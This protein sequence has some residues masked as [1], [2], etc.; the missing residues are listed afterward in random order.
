MEELAAGMGEKCKSLRKDGKV[1]L[2]RILK[3]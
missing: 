3:K 2:K 1:L